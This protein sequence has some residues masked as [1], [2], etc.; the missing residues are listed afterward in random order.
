MVIAAAFLDVV[1]FS[2]IQIALPTIRTEFA[3]SLADAQWIVGSYGL[4]L[5]GFLLLSGRAGDIYGQKKLFI[6]GVS[7]F[8][9]ASLTGGLAPSLLSLVLS[10]AVQGIG[11]AI[12]TVTALAIFA[13]IFPEGQA[14]NKALGLFVAVL[15]AGFAA[16][17]LAGGALTAAFGWRS[18]MFVNVP[19]GAVTA[20]LSVSYLPQTGGLERV[21]HLDLWGGLSSTVGVLIF[22]YALTNAATDGFGSVTTLVPLG[23]S[24]LMLLAFLVIE[25]RSKAPLVP[26]GF[27]RRGV[28]LAANTIALIVAAASGGLGFILTVYL[29][30]VLG[31]SALSTGLAFLPS[32]IVF[33][34]V[35]GWGSSWFVNR[36][37]VKRVLLLSMGFIIAGNALLTQISESGNLFG[38]ELG[39]ILWSLGA[40][41]GFPALFIAALTGIKPGEEGLASGLIT[42]SQRVGF[43]LGLALLVTVASL[44]TAQPMGGQGASTAAV[45]L[46]FQYAFVAATAI[47]I[48]GLV[49]VYMI[50]NGKTSNVAPL[51]V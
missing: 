30:Q 17:S 2:I 49:L 39:T 21:K 48:V 38:I 31:Y 34:V 24:G 14:R 5:A 42:T 47:S 25:S 8:S 11:A 46:G 20:V 13:Q 22:V 35:G 50:K 9:V 23:V 32:S 40:S 10:R 26:L 29:Q 12:S 7:L 43:P 41:I 44:V 36:F 28:F 18:V 19:I 33:L 1:D 15:S 4:T 6:A 16:G 3:I 51:P 45:V 27:L 37:G